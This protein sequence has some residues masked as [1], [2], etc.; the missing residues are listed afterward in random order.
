[1]EELIHGI[2]GGISGFI[3]VLTWYPLETLRLN[4]QAKLFLI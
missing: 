1:M 2:S 4:R 3:A